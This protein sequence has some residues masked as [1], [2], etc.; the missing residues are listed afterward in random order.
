[1][2]IATLFA[3][4]ASV[5]TPTALGFISKAISIKKVVPGE[6]NAWSNVLLEIVLTATILLSIFALL[7]LLEEGHSRLLS[8]AEIKMTPDRVF[9]A[10]PTAF[11]FLFFFL[12]IGKRGCDTSTQLVP[13]AKR[14]LG[15]ILAFSYWSIGLVAGLYIFLNLNWYVLISEDSLTINRFFAMS[16]ERRL[17]S[18]V[19]AIQTAPKLISPNGKLV[20]RRE[21]VVRFND[22]AVLSSNFFPEQF[23]E[24]KELEISDFISAQSGLPIQEIEVFQNDEL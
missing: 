4:I 8:A 2:L 3:L 11:L 9:F 16:E 6:Q 23:D 14:W 22:G 18:D 1:M 19:T 17:Y 20:D 7:V 12:K 21:F 13:Q 15:R 10:P 24:K 5:G